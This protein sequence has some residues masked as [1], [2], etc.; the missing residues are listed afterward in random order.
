MTDWTHKGGYVVAA[1]FML[2][3]I[4]ARTSRVKDLAR[5]TC[6]S[7]RTVRIN[8]LDAARWIRA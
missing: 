8:F 5:K 1:V 6:E 3:V 7:D 4:A 2:G